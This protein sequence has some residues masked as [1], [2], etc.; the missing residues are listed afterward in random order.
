[1][2]FAAGAGP[3]LQ[4]PDKG[5]EMPG[6]RGRALFVPLLRAGGG[7]SRGACVRATRA[8]GTFSAGHETSRALG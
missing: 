7:G 4:V 5:G 1:M 2:Q 3:G 8:S 6:R